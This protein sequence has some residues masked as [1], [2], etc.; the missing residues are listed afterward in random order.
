MIGNQEP[1][2]QAVLLA[3]LP[4]GCETPGMSV[5]VLDREMYTEAAAARLLGVAQGTLNY[6]L[7]AMLG[8]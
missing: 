2:V 3:W 5:T 8:S 1:A 4:A 7:E 6:W